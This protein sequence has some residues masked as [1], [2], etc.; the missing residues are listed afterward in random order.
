VVGFCSLILVFLVTIGNIR[1]F[2]C[3]E[4]LIFPYLLQ[5]V[6]AEQELGGPGASAGADALRAPE[7]GP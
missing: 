1:G 2:V 7:G 6:Q 5:V 3:Y 4:L